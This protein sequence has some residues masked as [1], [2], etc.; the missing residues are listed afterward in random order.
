[1]VLGT[2]YRPGCGPE[3]ALKSVRRRRPAA[4]STPPRPSCSL[5]GSWPEGQHW[6][7]D[8][9]DKEETELQKGEEM[10]GPSQAGRHLFPLTAAA[11]WCC[12]SAC[13]I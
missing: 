1:M 10:G 9:D 12:R 8:L 11:I 13:H 4:C 2:G 5:V 3:P 6:W 7:Y